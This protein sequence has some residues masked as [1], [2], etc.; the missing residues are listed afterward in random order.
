MNEL[1]NLIKITDLPQGNTPEKKIQTKPYI[2]ITVV[3]VVGIALLFL[4]S[5]RIL[6]V[7]L[8]ALSLF[9]L[10]QI[11]GRLQMEIYSTYAVFYPVGHPDECQIFYYNDVIQWSIDHRQG[12]PD[13]MKIELKDDK[14]ILQP[15]AN[16]DQVLSAFNKKMADKE[17]NRR[18]LLIQNEKDKAEREARKKAAALRKQNK[19]KKS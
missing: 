7:V 18:A 11:K 12:Q 4:K 9:A 2:A 6:G 5:M 16:S 14:M 10:W 1:A 13:T 15:I 8:I 19:Q 3:L 17:Y